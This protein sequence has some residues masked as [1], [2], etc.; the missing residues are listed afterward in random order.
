MKSPKHTCDGC[1]RPQHIWKN[2][3]ENGQRLRYCRRC[4]SCQR[5]EHKPTRVSK[6][7]PRSLKK[8]KLDKQ[9]SMLRVNF[10][11]LH[12]HCQ[13]ALPGCSRVASEVHHKKG[14]V[15][16][17]YL[18]VRYWL[19]VCRSCHQ[20]IETHPADAQEKGFSIKRL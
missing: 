11:T 13:A 9:Y 6:P 16:E 12:Q 8:I 18:D 17:L 20:W 4:W 14:K 2:V 3:V 1:K 7:R 15:G 5:Q 10:L 19:A